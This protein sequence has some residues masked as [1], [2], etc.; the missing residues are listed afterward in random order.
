MLSGNT[1]TLT[2]WALY[3][4]VDPSPGYPVVI[5]NTAFLAGAGTSPVD[6][7]L[8]IQAGAAIDFGV[9]RPGYSPGERLTDIR[10]NDGDFTGC[11]VSF[12]CLAGSYGPG[13]ETR[14]LHNTTSGCL[15]GCLPCP[16]GAVCTTEAVPAPHNSTEGK[17]NPDG[18]SQTNSSCRQCESG[19]FQ[20]EEGA[21]ECESCRAGTFSA[22]KG[23]TRCDA[24]EAG[25]Y[26]DA[27][28]ASSASVF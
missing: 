25:G 9:C 8:F 22:A 12:P 6:S 17:Y 1:A 15:P 27:P 14:D 2:G 13:G 7:N 18:G 21:T 11:P 5:T 19:K 23:R 26:C 4:E 3:I 24:C 10:V 20:T 16:A 28:G